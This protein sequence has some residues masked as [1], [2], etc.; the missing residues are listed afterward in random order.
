MA[1]SFELL[2][3]SGFDRGLVAGAAKG[4]GD[5][6]HGMIGDGFV[7]WSILVGRFLLL[8]LRYPPPTTNPLRF[9]FE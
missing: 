1:Q 5:R 4:L 6:K 3:K 9:V 2:I 7:G 8:V